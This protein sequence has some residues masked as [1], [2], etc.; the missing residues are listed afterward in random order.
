MPITRGTTPSITF[1]VPMD[2]TDFDCE[3]D[4]GKVGDPWVIVDGSQMVAEYGETS[5][6]A[7]TLTEEQTLALRRGDAEVQL[8]IAKG[9]VSLATNRAP[10]RV[11]GLIR[12]GKFRNG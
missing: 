3:L 9:D 5:T 2:L 10:I 4:I 11:E 12:E 1:T 6:I 7:F 8:R